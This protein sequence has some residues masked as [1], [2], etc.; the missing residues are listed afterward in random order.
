MDP[1]NMIVKLCAA[2]MAAEMESR[3][4]KALTLY[5]E[6]WTTA[7]TA[8]ERCIAAHFLARQQDNDQDTLHWNQEALRLA[9]VVEDDSVQGFY[10]SLYLNLAYSHE[11]LGHVDEAKQ[12]YKLAAVRV[13]ELPEDLYGKRV[14]NS[15]ARHRQQMKAKGAK[16]DDE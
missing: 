2:G 7:V 3:P 5:E 6:A 8:T 10:P 12:Y 4:D 11:V 9:D 1:E 15:I 14:R 16:T 13:D